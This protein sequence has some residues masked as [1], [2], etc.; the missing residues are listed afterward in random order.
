MNFLIGVNFHF[1]EHDLNPYARLGKARRIKHSSSSVV[2]VVSN[3]AHGSGPILVMQGYPR[4]FNHAEKASMCSYV[5]GLSPPVSA[6]MMRSIGS[7]RRTISHTIPVLLTPP[8][9]DTAIILAPF[10][11]QSSPPP[12]RS[13]VCLDNLI[14]LLASCLD[15]VF[16][17]DKL[18]LEISNTVFCANLSMF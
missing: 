6:K 12:A 3:T 5:S 14:L 17:D 18:S 10:V 16:Q 9:N 4:S 8:P 1:T 7:P 2:A 13:D 11:F 15:C